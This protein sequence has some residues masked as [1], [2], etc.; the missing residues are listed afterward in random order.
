MESQFYWEKVNFGL[1]PTLRLVHAAV[2]R[3]S[4][5]QPVYA[6]AAKQLYA[7]HYFHTALE[8]RTIVN[9]PAQPDAGTYLV[10]V[11]VARSDGLTGLFGGV[12]KS[13]VRTTSRNA[14]ASALN[15]IKLMAESQARR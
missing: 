4:S 7:S 1:R 14:L 15:A 2:Y 13:K 6:A 12:V 10:V 3:S 5:Q 11:N 8:I 9:E